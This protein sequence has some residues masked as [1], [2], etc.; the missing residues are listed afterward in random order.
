MIDADDG[1]AGAPVLRVLLAED[2]PHLG[3]LLGQFLSARGCAVTLVRDGHEALARLQASDFDVALTDV[4]MPGLDGM[5]LLAA[6]RRMPLAPEVIVIT[7]NGTSDAAVRA[8]RAGAYDYLAK[9]YRMAEIELLVRRAA[10]K[11][12]LRRSRALLQMSASPAATGFVTADATLHAAVERLAA[13]ARTARVSLLLG[14]PGTGRRTLARQLHAAAGR[15]G[16]FVVVE[17]HRHAS[18]E[19]HRLLLGDDPGADAPTS[20]ACE[21]G[22]EPAVPLARLAAG[23]TL[24]VAGVERLA[25]P[26]LGA[27]LDACAAE[28]GPSLVAVTACSYA[29]LAVRWDEGLAARLSATMLAVPPLRE[30]PADVALLGP[31]LAARA[32]GATVEIAPA[33]LRAL[34]AR[35]WPGNAAELAAVVQAAVARTGGTARQLDLADLALDAGIDRAVREGGVAGP[36]PLAALERRHVAAVLAECAWHQGRAAASLGISARTLYRMIRRYGLARPSTRRAAR[37]GEGGDRAPG[38]GAA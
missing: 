34:G 5:A 30:R 18:V 2:E 22:P 14:E 31:L 3:A 15:T 10:E 29:D 17:L 26:T 7:G 9:P 27:L 28:G 25:A 36:E 21:P 20:R 12:Q 32:A 37:G 19:H 13:S 16:A 24:C 11:R 1:A 35:A 4:Q 33:A 6:A 8:L 23:G 38:L